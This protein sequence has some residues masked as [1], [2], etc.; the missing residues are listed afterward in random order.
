[1]NQLTD[2]PVDPTAPASAEAILELTVSNRDDVGPL[3]NVPRD[4]DN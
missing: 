4:H 3:P 1:M 2:T